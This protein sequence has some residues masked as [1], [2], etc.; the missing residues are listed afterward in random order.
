MERRDL[1]RMFDGLAPTRE[2]EEAVLGCLLQTERKDRPMKKLKKLTVAAIAAAL[3]VISCAAAVVTGIDQRLIDYF[4]GGEQVEEVLLPSAMA[5]DV[6]AEDN[7]AVFHVTQV[8][9]D[10]YSIA[11]AADFTAPEGT[12]LDVNGPDREL[13]HFGDVGKICFLNEAGAPVEVSAYRCKWYSLDD[14]YPKDNR[15]SLL[16]YL[17]VPGGLD[18]EVSSLV[19]DTE[20]LTVFDWTDVDFHTFYTGNWPLEIPLPQADMG[21]TQQFDQRV[22]ELDGSAIRLK[23]VYLSPITMMVILERE[24]DFSVDFS[25]E[26]GTRQSMRWAFALDGEH[27]AATNGYEPAVDRAILTD[28]DGNEIPMECTN[29]SADMANLNQY[30]HLFRLTQATDMSQ[31]QGGRLTLRVGDGSVDIPLDNLVPAE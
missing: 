7:G 13:N 24:K 20:N 14:G 8:L 29:G 6:S 23:E 9:R 1:N 30:H 17:D 3:M 4:G 31:L 18:W 21:C 5:V 28:R 16:Y 19:L 2:Q 12:V 15:L 11:V 22:G 27:F 10:R 25:T 26:E